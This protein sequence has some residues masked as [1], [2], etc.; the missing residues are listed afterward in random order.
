MGELLETAAL[1]GQ[2][3]RFLYRHKNNDDSLDGHRSRSR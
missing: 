3:A 1:R 2:I